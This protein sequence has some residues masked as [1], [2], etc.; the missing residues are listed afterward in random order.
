V[1]RLA[2]ARRGSPRRTLGPPLT[3]G[4]PRRPGYARDRWLAAGIAAAGFAAWELLARAGVISATFFPAPTAIGD[5]VFDGTASGELPRHLAATLRRVLPGLLLGGA[6]GLLAGV[7]M[8]WSVRLRAVSDPFVAALHPIPKLALLP[9][10]IIVFGIGE[11]AKVA[12]VAAAAFFPILIN[13]MAGVRQIQPAQIEAARSYGAGRLNLLRHVILPGSLPFVL[14]GTRLAANLA[15][16]VTIA[17][18]MTAADT[19]L[20][21]LIWTAWQVLRV[22]QLYAALVVIA[23]LGIALNVALDALAS[24]FA[25]W[26]QLVP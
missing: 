26:A 25:A 24:R 20:G 16:L 23:V 9:L 4:S 6:P 13:A 1:A 18:E 8:G 11:P 22:E 3:P 15:L 7:A 12:V 5:A 14:A 21:S 2:P 19:G 17:V 10:F